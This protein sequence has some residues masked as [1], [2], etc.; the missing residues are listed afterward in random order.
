MTIAPTSVEESSDP[1][2]EEG[3]RELRTQGR[4]EVGVERSLPWF[5]KLEVLYSDLC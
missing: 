2:S 1:S 4:A 5:L 3:I